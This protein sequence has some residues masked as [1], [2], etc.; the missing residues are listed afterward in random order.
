PGL[1]SLSISSLADDG[2][3]PQREA[4]E[5]A[6]RVGEAG[7]HTA[8]DRIADSHEYDRNSSRLLPQ[9]LHRPSAPSHDYIRIEGQELRDAIPHTVHIVGGPSLVELHIITCR[10]A[11]S[12][13]LLP[14]R[15]NTGLPYL[16]GFGERDQDSD[17]ALARRLLRPR[18]ER[19]RRRAAKHRDEFAPLHSITPSAD[20]CSVSGT[21]KPSAFAVL[22]L[23][24]SSNFVGRCTGRSAGLAPLRM[25]ST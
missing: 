2:I 8:L 25:R 24:I 4:G 3:F 19:P 1:I 23:I 16:I 17:F 21:A 18:R 15:T 5:V 20:A 9:S 14:Q 13:Q 12:G 10:P 22:R 11:Q 6:A 7:D